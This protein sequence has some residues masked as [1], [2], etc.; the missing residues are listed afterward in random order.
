MDDHV[1]EKV[2]LVLEVLLN[3]STHIKDDTCLNKLIDLLRKKLDCVEDV[4]DCSIPYFLQ[5]IPERTSS[6]AVFVFG[7]HV[8]GILGSQTNLN[9]LYESH[10]IDV[11]QT[12]LS[13]DLVAAPAIG[14]AFYKVL[15]TIPLYII[16]S[17]KDLMSITVEI[18]QQ[19][20]SLFLTKSAMQFVVFY[21]T[22]H[23]DDLEEHLTEFLERLI[24]EI[25]RKA[26]NDHNQQDSSEFS[27]I[28]VDI[29]KEVIILEPWR[30]WMFKRF[31]DFIEKLFKIL[32]S[33]NE[34]IFDGCLQCLLGA[35]QRF[36]GPALREFGIQMLSSI[37]I[38]IEN[39]ITRGQ[40]A[41]S[42]MMNFGL[43][44]EHLEWL[45]TVVCLPLYLLVPLE[46]EPE[47][48]KQ[49]TQR[50]RKQL[51]SRPRAIKIFCGT[52]EKVATLKFQD[53]YIKD[54]V[55][56]C[57]EMTVEDNRSSQ[58]SDIQSYIYGSSK[59]QQ[60]CLHIFN[61][62]AWLPY[63]S[64]IL[65]VVISVC[66]NSMVDN[67]TY[68]KCLDVIH[69][70]LPNILNQRNYSFDQLPKLVFALQKHLCGISWESR[71]AT[72]SFILKVLRSYKD[73]TDVI[74]WYKENKLDISVWQCFT[75][76]EG[77]VRSTAVDCLADIILH[78]EL[79][80]HL[81]T[82]LDIDVDTVTSRIEI[83]CSSDT[84]AFV[85]RSAVD[86]ITKLWEDYSVLSSNNRLS[87]LKLMSNV[88]TKD[89][90]W[91]VKLKVLDFW[92]QYIN[93]ELF[94]CDNLQVTLPSYTVKNYSSSISS[95]SGL[96][97]NKTKSKITCLVTSGCLK[98]LFSLADDFDRSVIQKALNTTKNVKHFI[99]QNNL[100]TDMVFD[101]DYVEENC[102]NC[103]KQKFN[104]TLNQ[105]I[106]FEE[107]NKD[108]REM[109]DWLLSVDIDQKL[110]TFSQTCDE[111][112]R[113]PI[114]LLDD[115]LLYAGSH[116]H[117][118]EDDNTVID[119]Y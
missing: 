15:K 24:I 39:D 110:A 20:N 41:C 17:L 83:L 113:N 9:A 21:F 52:L 68:T 85:R 73:D 69:H 18:F 26:D 2:K 94:E 27:S 12:T 96:K 62:D 98:S 89:F 37:N 72:L 32:I 87:I 28:C 82:V 99:K 92:N 115:I 75:D 91:E 117:E 57:F 116:D 46:E 11:L 66:E 76:S 22:K 1:K 90:D 34:S 114:S 71:E 88:M 79:Q 86:C 60:K 31:P 77:Y 55:M 61:K 112:E 93:K 38:L 29:V 19:K 101:K 65:S 67:V 8:T 103:K 47:R 59:I 58:L 48:I 70:F 84:E 53:Q 107:G 43:W 104:L 118:D 13:H 14:E 50:I 78:Q 102:S 10:V 74:A 4:E 95:D 49:T 42:R 23:S 64:R 106:S 6:T 16:Q 119:C 33:S 80:D 63:S 5:L 51:T 105:D 81:L 25:N 45:K 36:E 54:M 56:I 100:L 3:S 111:Y 30:T 7:I 108:E 35:S 40:E 44:S 97:N 109:I